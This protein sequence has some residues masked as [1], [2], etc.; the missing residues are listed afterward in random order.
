M[1]FCDVLELSTG[2]RSKVINYRPKN[3]VKS[4]IFQVVDAELEAL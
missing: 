2:K 3:E 1:W 4:L